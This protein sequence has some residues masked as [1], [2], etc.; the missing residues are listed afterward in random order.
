ARIELGEPRQGVEALQ[1]GLGHCG[2]VGSPADLLE[3]RHEPTAGAV[4]ELALPLVKQAAGFELLEVPQELL[5][6]EIGEATA[7][8]RVDGVAVELHRDL[9]RS[10]EPPRRA[11]TEPTRRRFR[12]KSA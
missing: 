11:G 10:S 5:A 6:I 12:P 4:Q 2:E 7:C 1:Q 9:R 3:V 8:L